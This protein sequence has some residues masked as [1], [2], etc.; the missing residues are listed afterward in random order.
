MSPRSGNADALLEEKEEVAVVVDT[1]DDDG[2][3]VDDDQTPIME[4]Q[5]LQQNVNDQKENDLAS[6]LSIDL[7]QQEDNNTNRKC[8]YYCPNFNIISK[9]KGSIHIAF[10]SHGCFITASLFYL[11][12]AFVHIT[13]LQ[14]TSNNDIPKYVSNQDDDATW[15][16][17]T[18]NTTNGNSIEDARDEYYIQYKLYYLLGAVFFV[19]MGILDLLRYCDVLNVAMML[20]GVAGVVSALSETSKQEDLWDKI[21][22]HLYLMESYTLLHREHLSYEGW[23]HVFRMGDVFFLIGAVF[24]VVDSYLPTSITVAYLDLISCFLWLGSSLIDLTAEIYFLKKQII[25]TDEYNI[26]LDDVECY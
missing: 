15:Y 16:D 17:Y 8:Y 18:D 9:F 4:L 10:L 11:K 19:F 7:Q 12:L 1:A 25:V 22:V 14:Y 20:A 13:W 23:T 24:D 21:S 2:D 26:D 5:K 6:T 3:D